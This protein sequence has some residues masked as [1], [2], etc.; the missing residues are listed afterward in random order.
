MQDYEL[1]GISFMHCRITFEE[2]P[3]PAPRGEHLLFDP[4]G[5]EI[6]FFTAD[7]R[8]SRGFWK[9]DLED[10]SW[11]DMFANLNVNIISF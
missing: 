2:D 11:L 10:C 7:N 6:H 8:F 3:A 5:V 4:K 1:L 9:M